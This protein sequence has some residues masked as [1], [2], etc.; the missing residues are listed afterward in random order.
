MIGYDICCI[1]FITQ[2]KVVTPESTIYM[3]GGT[4]FY[5]A[6]AMNRLKCENFLLVTAV[7]K[8]DEEVIEQ[9]RKANVAVKTLPTARSVCFENIYT[10]NGNGRKQRVTAKA[11][12]FTVEGLRDVD[13]R[14]VHLGSLLADD[15][16][17]D[18]IKY[19]SA[20]CRLSLDVQG[21]LRKV[22]GEEVLP[23]D[24]DEKKEALKYVH[25]LKANEAEMEVLTRCKDPHEAALLIADWG[26]E[27]VLLTLGDCGS[28]IYAHGQFYDIPAYPASKIVDATGCGD[29]YMAGYLYMRNRNA[30]YR[31]AGCFAAAMCTIKLQSHGPFSATE[32]A[33]EKII[34]GS[35]GSR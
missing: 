34:S 31:E 14:I 22:E 4:S 24:W 12:P 8:E 30:S 17:L 27:E 18:V 1:G 20:K 19:L 15:F 21:F 11:T 16:P 10:D 6:H 33:V 3:P 26:V 7:A 25:I 32:E 28:L 29:T 5:F 23:V 13:A 9:I 35:S 2:D